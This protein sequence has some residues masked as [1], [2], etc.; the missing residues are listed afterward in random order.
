M[1]EK[2]NG[3]G[4]VPG[5]LPKPEDVPV[6]IDSVIAHIINDVKKEDQKTP[7]A[8]ETSGEVTQKT[9][10]DFPTRKEIISIRKELQPG[11]QNAILYVNRK[12]DLLKEFDQWLKE[13]GE[14]SYPFTLAEDFDALFGMIEESGEIIMADKSY[15]ADFLIVKIKEIVEKKKNGEDV[16]A[17]IDTITRKRKLRETVTN[18]L[19][20]E[21]K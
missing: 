12:I 16:D 6:A 1:N 21:I 20:K 9:R 18:L 14:E 15:K 19:E 13:H 4:F 3:G 7:G 10:D 11:N 17:L 5:E 2:S 8:I